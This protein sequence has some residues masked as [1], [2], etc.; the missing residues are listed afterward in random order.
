MRRGG[1]ALGVLLV[2]APACHR[3]QPPRAECLRLDGPS[4]PVGFSGTFTITAS[5]ACP[6]RAGGHIVWEQVGGVPLAEMSMAR[7]GFELRARMPSL[8]E[9]RPGD[10][11]WGVVPLSPRTRGEIFLHATWTDGGDGVLDADIRVAAAPRSRGLPNTP[12]GARVYLG[13]GPWRLIA[14]PSRSH[15]QVEPIGG[16]SSLVPDVAGDWRLKGND[17]RE[18]TL[19]SMRYDETPL[20]CGRSDCHRAITDAAAA[21]PMTTVL[22]R[23]MDSPARPAGYP[24]CALACHA[25]GEPGALDGGFGHVASELGAAG[26]LGRRW[27]ELPRDLRRVGGVGCLACHGPSAIPDAASRWSVLRADVCAVCHDAPPRYGHVVAWGGTA[28]ARADRDPRAG[29]EP[30]CARCHTTW[31]FLDAV[32]TPERGHVDRSPP[33]G[34]GPLGISCSACHAV[35]DAKRPGATRLLRETPVP[36]LL[37]GATSNVCLPCHT[38]DAAD[39]R[40]TATAAALWLGRGGLD[41]AT[42]APMTGAPLH[43]GV[44]GGCIGCHRGGPDNIDRGAGHGFRATAAACAPCHGSAPPAS[45]VR[46]RAQQLWRRLAGRDVTDPAH[47][48]VRDGVTVDRRTPYGRAVWD[49]L[50]VLEDPAA[51]AHNARY[52]RALLDASASVID[53]EIR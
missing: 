6:E 50:L 11:P 7:D 3:H 8:A 19:R 2:A 40:P 26:N 13:G 44:A 53:K 37:A 52:A 32:A 15:A 42:G 17:A 28:M 34:V 47:A 33:T 31:G 20:D 23:L 30:A 21:S 36:A 49:L 25:T 9:I 39:A 45:D 43:A 12:I 4:D 16:V 10:L 48:R 38:P 46:A 51:G 35:H 18:I 22:A 5:L 41:P 27:E 14:Q 24:A 1:I 29:S